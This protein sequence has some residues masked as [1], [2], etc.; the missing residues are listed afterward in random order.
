M[1]IK[2]IQ[3]SKDIEN[4]GYQTH[5]FEADEVH[6]ELIYYENR[7]RFRIL[8]KSRTGDRRGMSFGIP[9]NFWD[10]DK[11]EIISGFFLLIDY[12]KEDTKT[13]DFI[14]CKD[15]EVYITNKGQTIDKIKVN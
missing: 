10:D 6:H 12:W 3:R 11:P 4:G 2:I 14:T 8:Y 5:I 15:C 7:E 9:S 1:E 13:I